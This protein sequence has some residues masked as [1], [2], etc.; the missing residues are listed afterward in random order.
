M[1]ISFQHSVFPLHAVLILYFCRMSVAMVY[2]GLSL[3]TS[4]LN[5][6]VY[7]NCFLSAAIDIAVY[8]AIGLLVNRAP[9]PTLLFCMLI[10]CGIMLLLIQLVPEGLNQYNT[11]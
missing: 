6:N 10:L 3:N 7:L 4:N 1:K 11:D 2:F 9:R 5:G 8:V